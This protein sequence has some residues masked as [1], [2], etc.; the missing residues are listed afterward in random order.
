MDPKWHAARLLGLEKMEEFYN[1]YS[2][3]ILVTSAICLVAAGIAL[4]NP[5]KSG[6]RFYFALMMVSVTIWNL[7]IIPFL[8]ATSVEDKIFW[9]LI[10][11]LGI[12]L[13]PPS[14]MAFALEQTGRAELLTARNLTFI[15]GGGVIVYAL[16]VTNER[17]HLLW[18]KIDLLPPVGHWSGW[19]PEYGP[20]FLLMNGWAYVL[21]FAGTGLLVRLVFRSGQQGVFRRQAAAILIAVLLPMTANLVYNM[22]MS[23][24]PGVE[25]VPLAFSV[26]GIIMAGGLWGLKFLDLIPVARDTVFESLADGVVVLDLFNRIVDMNFAAVAMFGGGRRREKLLGQDLDDVLTDAVRKAGAR[27][28]DPELFNASEEIEFT[29]RDGGE[30]MILHI[31]VTPLM[32]LNKG[33][34]RGRLV[35]LRDITALKRQELDLI[36]ARHL[37]DQANQAKS[38]FL[39]TMR[40][41]P[42]RL[43]ESL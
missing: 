15:F 1:F 19:Q 29:P 21:L 33:T 4:L 13:V 36:Q 20:I 42:F 43:V 9:S 22:G 10:E 18:R 27:L 37:A 8:L 17:H 35:V 41:F 40:W 31:R 12:C 28:L 34:Y 38:A 23:P 3:S 7:P 5:Q 6:S 2:W 39:A 14:V 24:L 11:Y 30:N 26:S 25:M 16:A 32:D